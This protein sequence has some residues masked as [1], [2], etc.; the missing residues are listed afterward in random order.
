M[1]KSES[2][3]N[4]TCDGFLEY[5]SKTDRM[6][7]EE[8]ARLGSTLVATNQ[9]IDVIVTE[10]GI[11]R[12]TELAKS[13]A[14][15]MS[16]PYRENL[17]SSEVET[18]LASALLDYCETR[19]IIVLSV[20]DAAISIALSNPF[21]DE[22]LAALQFKFSRPVHIVIATRATV[23]AT[24]SEYRDALSLLAV[25]T[26]N[27][28]YSVDGDVTDVDIERLKDFASEAPIIRLVAR[29]LQDG[30]EAK[31]TDI[32][33]EP[34]ER[35]VRVRF[36]IDGILQSVKELATG[37]LAGVTTRI[38]I[39]SGLNIAERRLP[40]DGKLRLPIRGQ[41]VDFRVSFM[42]SMHGETIVLRILDKSNTVLKLN[43]LGFSSNA[44][45]TLRRLV[46]KP[47]GIILVT[48]PTGSGKTT[49]LFSLLDMI[50][51]EGNKIFTVEDP[52]EYQLE[53]VTQLQVDPL[54][55]L[56][57][58]RSL[59]SVLRQDPDVIL[60]GEIRD[61]ETAQ[62]AV[63]AAL[64]GHL[65]LSTLHTNSAVGAITRMRDMGIESFLLA[66]TVKGVIAQRLL[67]TT[68]SEVLSDHSNCI[69]CRGNGYSGRTVAYEI[70]EL[71]TEFCD[72]VSAGKSESVLLEISGIDED[73][74][75]LGNAN[76]LLESGF[77]DAAEIA[78][79][80]E[81]SVN[82]KQ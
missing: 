4:Y 1:N 33:I 48:G 26:A 62:I 17:Q 41:S 29:I 27:H 7:R 22:T 37:H 32:H 2:T 54:I 77:T 42:P 63:Q 56:D 11:L 76:M 60:V 79:V 68:C 51:H 13:L 70:L 14:D 50:N 31:A 47:N 39:M 52:V 49:T 40:Q 65:V 20:S 71:G 82:T 8:I 46:E 15:Y 72:F 61:R 12:D 38:K 59:R 25:D 53:G 81:T 36:R 75:I 28:N 24:L 34:N 73:S 3:S 30:V 21:D 67:R 80:F 45:G 10:L 58:V 57:F 69:S 6:P 78:R 44:T 55:G 16:L 64:T 19:C 9:S 74:S 43:Q 35:Y 5:L 66:A 18:Q 23:L